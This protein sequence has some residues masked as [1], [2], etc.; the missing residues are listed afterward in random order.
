MHALVLAHDPRHHFGAAFVDALDVD[1]Y[2]RGVHSRSDEAAAVGVRPVP[3]L[4][5]EGPP[6]WRPFEGRGAL[7]RA[8]MAGGERQSRGDTRGLLAPD[9]GGAAEGRGE[10]TRVR[11]GGASRQSSK[12][13]G[14]RLRGRPAL[15]RHGTSLARSAPME[16]AS[17]NDALQSPCSCVDN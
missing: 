12:G 5:R 3:T 7:A 14:G 16:R 10:A 2:G 1:A 17:Q 15:H 4:G 13:L 6:V 11:C 9:L 8:W